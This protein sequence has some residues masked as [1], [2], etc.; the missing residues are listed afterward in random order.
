MEIQFQGKRALVTGAGKGI[1]R[2][3]AKKL[4]ECGAETIALSRTQADLDSLKAEVQEIIPVL[5]DVAD[6]DATRKIVQNLGPIHLLVNNAGITRLG[7][8]LE[9]SMKDFEDVLNVN[10][11]AVFNISQVVAKGMVERGGGGSIVNISSVA[12]T[13]ALDEHIA[14]CTSKSAVDSITR[15]MALELGKHKIRVNSVNPTVT[16]TDMAAFAWSDPA[17]SGPMLAKIPM[18]KFV[19]LEDV[20]NTVLFLLSDKSAITTGQHVVLDGGMS[21]C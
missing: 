20:V 16:W 8:F 19:E 12:S 7:S 2:A 3:I 14:Y 9:F 13:R 11:K 10:T 6:F 17:K 15:V 4:V 1:G 18:G 5:C 21:A